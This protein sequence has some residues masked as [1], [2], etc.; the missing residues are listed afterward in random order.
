MA[1]SG[2]IGNSGGKKGRSGRKPKA[3]EDELRKLIDS[4]WTKAEQKKALKKVV[5]RASAGSLESLKFLTDYR[6]GKPT[7]RPDPMPHP[8]DDAEPTDERGSARSLA[9]LDRARARR[10]EQAGA[11]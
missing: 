7:N 10:N 1:G 9:I 3:Q 6:F 8:P 2:V 11:Q 5:E 4:V